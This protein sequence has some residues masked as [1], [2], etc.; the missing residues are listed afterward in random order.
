[1]TGRYDTQDV[2][3]DRDEDRM[4]P[5][6]SL[7]SLTPPKGES[8]Q[9]RTVGPIA[10]PDPLEGESA[11]EGRWWGETPVLGEESIVVFA[12]C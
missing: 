11:A 12:D 1:M 3:A 5:T 4:P 10:Q 2:L 8:V 9:N 7:R 6:S